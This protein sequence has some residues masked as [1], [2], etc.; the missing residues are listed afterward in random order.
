MNENTNN[1]R[2]FTLVEL[3][4]VIVVLAIVMLI[5]LQAVLPSM[6]R[7]RRQTFAIEANGAIDA[8]NTYF[9]SSMLTGGSGFPATEG[10]TSCVTIAKLY[11][12]GF[13]E[14][15]NNYSGKV[16]VQK[17]GNIHL[18]YVFLEKDDTWMVNGAGTNIKYS[19]SYSGTYNE[20]INEDDVEDYRQIADFATCPSSQ[21]S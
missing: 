3:L 2:G 10:G 1:L 12:E 13:T 17:K 19:G 20:D 4:A 21:S 15:G 14:L 5:A 7:A 11:E 9:M 16:I 18:Y 6:E 8:A